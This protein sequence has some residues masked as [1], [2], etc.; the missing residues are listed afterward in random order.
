MK[1]L[2]LLLTIVLLCFVSGCQTSATK[3]PKA[4]QTQAQASDESITGDELAALIV[5]K[6]LTYG[7]GS[8]SEVRADGTYEYT[9]SKGNKYPSTYAI[10]QDGAVCL[11]F[12]N[13]GSRC[14]TYVLSGQRLVLVNQ[15]GSRYEVVENMPNT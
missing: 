1:L 12:P 15:Q 8:K 4:S 5:G 3:S 11:K 14:D 6:T 2:H 13:G 7:D 10:T 9:D